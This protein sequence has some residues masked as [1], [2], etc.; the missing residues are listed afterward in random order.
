MIEPTLRNLLRLAAAGGLLSLIGFSGGCSRTA[1]VEARA[2]VSEDIPIV[3][4]AKVGRQDLSHDMALTAEFRPFQEVDVM[5]K[6]AG[7]VKQIKVDVGDRVQQTRSWQLEIPEMA[8]DLAAPTQPWSEATPRWRAPMT[9]FSVPR[10][11]PDRRTLLISACRRV[12]KEARTWS[13]NRKSTTPAAKTLWPRLRSAAA[14]S[15][16]PRPSDRSKSTAPEPE[17]QY[18]DEYTRVMAP[19]AGVMTKR[20]ADTGSMIQAGTASQT[21]AMPVVRIS[22]NSF[23]A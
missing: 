10:R 23:C 15:G 1:K 6:V 21:Q 3:A 16:L 8:D 19:F 14:K 9:N 12:A 18:P 13:R 4:V 17:G 2:P 22:E 11:A 5:A 20:F 7:Y